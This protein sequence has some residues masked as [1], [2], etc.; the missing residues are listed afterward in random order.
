MLAMFRPLFR[1]V[2]KVCPA[3]GVVASSRRTLQY[4]F[5]GRRRQPL[6]TWVIAPPV[7]TASFDPALDTPSPYPDAGFEG[8]RVLSV[9]NVNPGKDHEPFHRLAHEMNVRGHGARL[10][11]YVAGTIFENQRP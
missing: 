2:Y 9:G 5:G 11:F 3:D 4:Y 8:V 7:D 10:R 6:Q 1:V